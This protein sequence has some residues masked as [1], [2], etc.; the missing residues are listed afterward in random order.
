MQNFGSLAHE[1][2]FKG[3]LAGDPV[4]WTQGLTHWV[5][6]EDA[7][8]ACFSVEAI[9]A[10]RQRF[11]RFAPLFAV[12]RAELAQTFGQIESPLEPAQALQEAL[13]IP[14]KVGVLL[15]KCDHLLPVAGS[16]KARG[17]THEVI[18]LAERL[19][20]KHGLITADSDYRALASSHARELFATHTVAV[21]ST[22][23]LG[24]AIG[25][26]AT[27]LGFRAEVHMS[28]D[29]KQWKKDRLHVLGVTIVEHSGDY[30]NAVEA[31]RRSAALN[32]LCH[33]V[34]DE[35]S[36]SLFLGYATAA[37]HLATQLAERCRI[38]DAN[39]PLIVYLPCGVGGAPAGITFGLKQIFGRNV[40]CV[41][42][43]PTSS[44]CFLAQ[45]LVGSG[46]IPAGNRRP[47]VYDLGLDNQTEADGLA[48]PRASTLAAAAVGGDV[49][50]V[51]TVRDEM[52]FH[53]LRLAHTSQGL[54]IEP[55]AAA[56]LAGPGM[57]LNTPQGRAYLLRTR[58]VKT[59][60]NSTHIAWLTGGGLMPNPLHGSAAKR[61]GQPEMEL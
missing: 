8:T 47:S 54:Q 48:V 25:S 59:L 58:L 7:A 42:A 33:F 44:P 30:A 40:H 46:H 49:A 53:H 29:A 28:A 16:V 5:P 12:I 13:Q 43:E 6:V 17:G 24:L 26:I 18:E 15:V 56:G 23:N 19:A 21:G 27:M 51:Y 61:H 1:F 50:G 32:P 11:Q 52:L 45:M 34:D 3:L 38:V 36:P 14:A 37:S 60:H 35:R 55:S 2:D 57:L 4:L 22:G 10:A 9:E 39:H 41:F 31:G 20:I